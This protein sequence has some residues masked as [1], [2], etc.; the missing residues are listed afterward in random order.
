[1]NKLNTNVV[2]EFIVSIRKDAPKKFLPKHLASA[3][4][5]IFTQIDEVKETETGC[6]LKF[7]YN[8]NHTKVKTRL[9]RLPVTCVPAGNIK[10]ADLPNLDVVSA[11]FPDFLLPPAEEPQKKKKP[12]TK[13][14]YESDSEEEIIVRRPKKFKKK[15]VNHDSDEEIDLDKDD[16]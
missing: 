2:T 9:S 14:K 7:G 3:C 6:M 13:R 11:L 10:D 12:T 4:R 8:A 16:E 1:M 15:I 5:A